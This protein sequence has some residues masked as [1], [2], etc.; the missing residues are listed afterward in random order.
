MYLSFTTRCGYNLPAYRGEGLHV[1]FDYGS[2]DLGIRNPFK[3]EGAIRTV[4][5]LCVVATGV[6]A[7]LAVQ[8]IVAGGQ[9]GHGIA[10]ALV[11]LV[12]TALGLRMLGIGL[13][14]MFRFFV[15][16]SVPADLA[17]NLEK[18]QRHKNAPAPAY[19]DRQLEQMLQG[20]QN[21]S[22][23]EPEDWFSRMV[24]SLFR[25]LL[26]LP[27]AYRNLAQRL[28]RAIT[29]TAIATFS[30]AIAWFSG[31]TGITDVNATPV[32]DWLAL[33]LSVYLLGVWFRA[34]P[35]LSRILN[36]GAGPVPNTKTLT[37]WIA[38]AILLPAGLAWLHANVYPFPQIPWSPFGYVLTL[39]AFGA[40]SVA[41]F[42]ALLASRARTTAPV[43]EVAEFRDNWQE[44]IHPQEVFI[45]FENIVMAN[46]RYKEVPNRMYRG[47]DPRLFEQGSNDK[48]E[49]AGEMIQEVQP[50]FHTI[51][52]VKLF[53]VLRVTGTAAGVLLLV[54]AAIMLY[55]LPSELFTGTAAQTLTIPAWVPYLLIVALFGRLMSNV[56]EIFWGEMQFESLMVYFQCRGTYT[57]SKLSTGTSIYDSTRSENTVVRSSMTLWLIASRLITS[58]FA[59]SGS[60]NLENR[61]YVLEMHKADPEL[62]SVIDDLRNFVS[63]RQSIASIDSQGDLSAAARI[64]QVNQ[65]TRYLGADQH[66]PLDRDRIAHHTGQESTEE[67]G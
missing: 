61:R 27:Y 40:A 13:F 31:A 46:R 45:H 50:V 67:P 16:R 47:F 48:G 34:S 7:L 36:E 21:I 56:A 54:S 15:G 10:T 11:G 64:H 33:V 29:Q 2:I 9:R 65:S 38:G 39:L 58:T 22:F 60:M 62:R 28:S 12:L 30:Y 35:R 23:E 24:H 20:R 53:Y 37:L 44:S 63:K 42:G 52:T 1:A 66:P 49:F 14:K 4:G 55:L 57:E 3:T 32:M 6:L 18:S 43:V 25:R 41:L 5:G 19:N 59:V 51:P 17:D 8:G 26:Y